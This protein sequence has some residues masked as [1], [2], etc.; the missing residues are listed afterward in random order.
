MSFGTVYDTNLVPYPSNYAQRGQ[1]LHHIN[2]ANLSQ[3]IN[4]FFSDRPIENDKYYIT[5][6]QPEKKNL[7]KKGQKNLIFLLI[8]PGKK[9]IS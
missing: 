2:S 5:E 9:V 4:Q 7:I 6:E 8:F 3:I 1:I